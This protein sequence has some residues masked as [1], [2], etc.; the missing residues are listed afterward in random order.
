[1]CICLKEQTIS[2]VLP[3]SRR[4]CVSEQELQEWS[5]SS[6]MKSAM[7]SQNQPSLQLW[8]AAYSSCQYARAADMQLWHT[9]HANASSVRDETSHRASLAKLLNVHALHKPSWALI[10]TISQSRHLTRVRFHGIQDLATWATTISTT[11]TMAATMLVPPTRAISTQVS[12]S[13][14]PPPPPPPPLPLL[15]CICPLK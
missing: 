5:L 13:I 12:F 3:T 4:K 7:A 11:T 8:Y 10:Y 15:I 6:C 9:E 14:P 1:M 2:A